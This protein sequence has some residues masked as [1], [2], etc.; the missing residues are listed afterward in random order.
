[1]NAGDLL[2]MRMA[3][4]KSAGRLYLCHWTL[5]SIRR[6]AITSQR[7]IQTV[8]LALAIGFVVSSGA[9]NDDEI[10]ISSGGWPP[11]LSPELRHDGFIAH[12]ISDVFAEEGIE[13]TFEFV[14]WARA[15]QETA[16]GIHDGTAVWMDGEG[17]HDDFLFSDPV[18][19]ET[20]VFFHRRDME[21]DWEDYTDLTDFVIGGI[22]GYSYGRAF[23]RAYEEGLL[24]VDWVASASLNHIK[25]IRGRIDL[26]PQEVNVGYHGLQADLDESELEQITHHPAPVH[27]DESYL[28]LSRA[29][30]GS[31]ELIER[32]NDRLAAFRESGRY[33]RY[34]E[35]FRDGYYQ[36]DD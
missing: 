11:F 33:D 9:A 3:G 27:S 21:F 12:L 7:H 17:R 35:N 13:V 22:Y 24:E 6:P 4:R 31:A 20:F 15:Y 5:R 2:A 18:M 29:L 16:A 28:L 1:V 23:D 10:V 32:F 19:E 34:H 30:P 14:P 8:G 25:L 26:Y 36:L